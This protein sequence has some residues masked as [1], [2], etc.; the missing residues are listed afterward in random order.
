MNWLSVLFTKK[1]GGIAI[2]SGGIMA[3]FLGIIDAKDK[4]IREMV[5]L[6]NQNIMAEVRHLKEGQ[7]D[8]KKILIRMEERQYN[9]NKN[10]GK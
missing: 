5:L 1:A 7:Q 6:K 10:K 4:S 2:G 8:M 9:Y 3:L